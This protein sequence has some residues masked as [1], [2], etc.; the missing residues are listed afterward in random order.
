M[1]RYTF[2]IVK[3][4]CVDESGFDFI[5]SD[6]I[7]WVFTA[8]AGG[9]VSTTTSRLF[10]NVDS[11]NTRDFL[12]D[13]DR[14]IVWPRKGDKAGATGPIGLSIQL[15]EADQGKPENIG[16]DTE[17][18]LTLASAAPAV[19][20]WVTAVGPVV[21]KSLLNFVSDDLMGSKTLLY[22][23]SRLA[24][25]LPVP[26]SS[27]AEKHRFGGNGGDLPFEVAGGPNYDLHIKVIRVA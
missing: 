10:G 1:A 22:P 7:F 11:G 20:S 5:G 17:I 25:Q 18:A 21:R 12:T 16:Q 8:N 24:T 6:E 15:W 3:F 4:D 13:N 26:G 27:F 19:D 9:K 14:N 23:M 2:K